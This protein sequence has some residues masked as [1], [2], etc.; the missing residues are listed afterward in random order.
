MRLKP[1]PKRLSSS[2]RKHRRPARLRPKHWPVCKPLFRRHPLAVVRSSKAPPRPPLRQQRGNSRL[3]TISARGLGL[4]SLINRMTGHAAEGHDRP[5]QQ[6]TARQ[7]PPMHAHEE[8]VEA[9]PE[10]E[11]IEIPAFLRRQAN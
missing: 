8:E 3:K 10:Q 6:Q 4:N 11:R 2:H 5:A 1:S 9:D 7:Q